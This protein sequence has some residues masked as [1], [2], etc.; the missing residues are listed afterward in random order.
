MR[1]EYL[2][3]A[4]AAMSLSFAS[5]NG[6]NESSEALDIVGKHVIHFNEPPKNIPSVVSVDAPLLGNGFTGVSIG[7]GPDST[8]FYVARNDFWRLKSGYEEGSPLLLGKVEMTIPELSGATYAVNQYIKD[9]TTEACFKKGDVS[10]TYKAYM[11]ATEDMMVVE[12]NMKGK[13]EMAVDLKLSPVGEKELKMTSQQSIDCIHLGDINTGV[14]DDGIHYLSRAFTDSVDIPSKAAIAMRV[15]GE[16]DGKIVLKEGKPQRLL[17]AFSSNFKSDDCVKT[18]IDKVEAQDNTTLKNLR[19]DHNAWWKNYWEKSYVSIPDSVIEQQYYVSLYG[20]ASSSRDL[21]FPSGIFGIWITKEFPAWGADYHLNYNHMAPY[22]G[23]YSCNRMEQA[24]PYYMPLLAFMDR[25]KYYSDKVTSIPDG[26]LLP[27]GIGP[28]GIETTNRNHIMEKYSYGWMI[29]GGNVEEGGLFWGQKSNAAYGVVNISMQFYHTWDK[30]FTEKV[31][32]YVKAVA[33]FWE[34]Y[35]VKEGD[36]YVIYKDAI[37]EG[38]VGTMNPVLSLGLV[39]MVMQTAIDMSEF[40]G[41][42]SD[43]KAIWAEKKEHLS[44]YCFQERDGKKVFL[45]AEKGY[46]WCGGNTLGIQ[47]VYPVGDIGL[48]SDPELVRVTKN[49]IDVMQRWL[50]MNGSNSFFPAA[51][52][53]GYNPDTILVHL[54]EYSRHT[55][56]NGFQQNNPHGIENYSTVPNT[57]NEMLC[58]GHQDIVRVFHVWPKDKDASFHNIRVEGAFLVSSALKDGKVSFLTIK[59]DKGRDLK[60]QNPWKGKKVEVKS[61]G[62]SNIMEGDFITMKTQEGATYEFLPVE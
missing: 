47:Q 40:L 37:H 21:D 53:V 31:Y 18:V 19:S 39:R 50:D 51:V 54:N 49:T 57:I 10:F 6:G 44:N 14:T 16:K 7:G 59:S 62:E 34:H 46:D 58:M 45:Y 8:V 26:V 25:G 36:R 61:N 11:A 24:D 4:L 52:R 48:E 30:A 41:V 38:T 23:L 5:C 13:D 2:F 3:A 55:H 9:A 43:K 42:D 20:I 15:D 27:V 29:D 28:L 35:L 60:L 17:L 12:M 32:P 22:Y 33:T 56:P 1:K